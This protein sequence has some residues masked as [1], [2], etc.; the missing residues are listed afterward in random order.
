MEVKIKNISKHAAVVIVL[1]LLLYLVVRSFYDKK[2][3]EPVLT[4]HRNQSF[5]GCSE[6][7][8]HYSGQY[9]AILCLSAESIFLEIHSYDKNSTKI[10]LNEGEVRMFL[11]FFASCIEGHEC[12]EKFSFTTDH[13]SLLCGTRA[14]LGAFMSVCFDY[15]FRFNSAFSKQYIFYP[16]FLHEL[17]YFI[18]AWFS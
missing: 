5:D 6:A 11:D 16:D 2:V 8:T 4:R 3:E 15:N 17:Y 9:F 10:S 7:V 18:K 1:A 14:D 12:G 13:T